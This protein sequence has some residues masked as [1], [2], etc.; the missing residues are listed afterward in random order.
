[1]IAFVLL[2]NAMS[3]NRM[4]DA[5]GNAASIEMEY[6]LAKVMKFRQY[7]EIYHKRQRAIHH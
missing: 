6:V 3:G 5:D 1:M 7:S 4:T 2:Y